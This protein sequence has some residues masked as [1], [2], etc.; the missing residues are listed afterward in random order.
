MQ[1]AIRQSSEVCNISFA[2]ITTHGCHFLL[3]E[4]QPSAGSL[5]PKPLNL[6]LNLPTLRL[7]SPSRQSNTDCGLHSTG[8]RIPAKGGSGPRSEEYFSVSGI[9]LQRA[10]VQLAN[11][12]AVICRGRLCRWRRWA[13]GQPWRRS[14]VAHQRGAREDAG[15][16]GRAQAR[17][18]GRGR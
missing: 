17:A 7:C 18:P 13:N 14:A 5:F 15:L 6:F 11:D 2:S 8:R 3:S 16:Q 10:H 1:R 4:C 9:R 12:T